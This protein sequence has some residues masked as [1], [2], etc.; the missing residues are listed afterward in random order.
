MKNVYLRPKITAPLLRVICFLI[1][2]GSGWLPLGAQGAEA[3]EEAAAGTQRPT[4]SDAASQK[5]IRNYLV[6]TGSQEA[7]LTLA[8]LVA[9]GSLTEASTNKSFELVETRDGRRHLTLNWRHLG[10]NFEEHYVFNG[11]ETWQQQV[12]PTKDQPKTLNGPSGQH[13]ANQSW[14]LQPFVLPTVADYTFKY[15]GAA[16][17]VG[18]PCHVVIGYGRKNVRSWFYFDKEKFLLLR[19]GGMGQL[20]GVPVPMDYRASRFKRQ[21]GVLLPTEVEQLAGDDT[22]GKILFETILVNQKIDPSIF[23]MPKDMTPVLRQRPVRAK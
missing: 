2:I 9:K 8:N 19:W 21:G 16:K 6:V 23:T 3:G 7:H 11:S 5:L 13:F 4:V 22:F 18:R 1:M 14:L 12:K 20:A 10:R 15:Q 17:V